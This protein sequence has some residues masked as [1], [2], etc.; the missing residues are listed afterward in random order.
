[1][2]SIPK[3]SQNKSSEAYAVSSS[4]FKKVFNGKVKILEYNQLKNYS[5]LNQ[6]FYPWNKVVLLYEWAPNFGH[7]TCL[8]RS[9]TG[10]MDFFDPYGY[11]PDAE[12]SFIPNSYWE[13]PYLSRLIDK[14]GQS[15]LYN[16]IDLQ[17]EG[18]NIDTCGRWVMER[19][20]N[21]DI[22]LNDFLRYWAEIPL[23]QRDKEIT[24]ATN[25]YLNA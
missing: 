2:S 3:T 13:A 20:L 15:V 16:P 10:Q 6:V 23:N 18:K 9:N 24:K 22:P 14:S 12:R 7:W 21:S 11:K 25:P 17:K 5:N 1:M 8:N 19:L 4:D